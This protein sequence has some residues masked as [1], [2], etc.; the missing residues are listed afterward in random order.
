MRQRTYVDDTCSAVVCLSAST[1]PSSRRHAA[2]TRAGLG[3]RGAIGGEHDRGDIGALGWRN[4]RA[5]MTAVLAGDGDLV[6]GVGI[7]ATDRAGC[8]FRAGR[9]TIER[10]EGGARP[11]PGD[12]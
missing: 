9:S 2:S 11:R 4:A 6:S 5:M 10:A 7:R 1:M 12:S 8:R 3:E